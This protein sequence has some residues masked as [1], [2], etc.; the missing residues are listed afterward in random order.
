MEVA[1]WRKGTDLSIASSV[2]V[3]SRRTDQQAAEGEQSHGKGI[4]SLFMWMV[5]SGL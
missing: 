1:V 2:I 5:G 3:R 4:S